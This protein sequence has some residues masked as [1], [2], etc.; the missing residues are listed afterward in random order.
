[1]NAFAGTS[2][3]FATAQSVRVD[4]PG[5]SYLIWVGE[6]LLG[7]I[8]EHLR[9]LVEGRRCALVT[10]PVV[11]QLYAASVEASLNAAGLSCVRVEI[12]DGEEFKTLAT[13]GQIYDA[14]IEAGLERQDPVLALG[15]GVVGDI[16]G[17]AAATYLRGV[18]FVQLPTTLLAQVDSSVGGKTGVNHRL[19]KNLIGAFYQPCSVVADVS[20][21]RTL[22]ERELRAGLAEVVK[23][24]VILDAELFALLEERLDSLLGREP[25]TLCA[26]VRRCCELK[27]SVVMRDE[28]ES[29]ERAIL[30]FG[31]TLGHALESVTDYRRYLHGEAI[32]IGMVFAA[33]LSA[34]LGIAAPEIAERL[35][36]LLVRAGLPVTVPGDIDP[37]RLLEAL[38]RDKKVQGGKIRFVCV[39]GLGRT[40]FVSLDSARV[41]AL[42]EAHRARP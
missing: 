23:Y 20:T 37:A 18:P 38:E 33:R 17:F 11:G 9:T 12:P 13:V 4:L 21:L 22:P 40:R 30:N 36:R 5:R 7:A 3:P 26:V 15:G 29:G 8:G 10:N 39:E 34:E 2:S 32:A 35:E 27:A 14:L 28:R 31:H 42:V 19:G 1:M 16:A 41:F 24:G 25:Q 6:G